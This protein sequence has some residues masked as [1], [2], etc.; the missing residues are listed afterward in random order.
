[1][2][3]ALKMTKKTHT[4]TPFLISHKTQD[5]CHFTSRLTSSRI[6]NLHNSEKG[7]E[8]KDCS[9]K[10]KEVYYKENKENVG[11]V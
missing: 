4:Q 3:S 9:S 8:I 6:I 11:G 7:G 5:S 10:H 2:R 1:M